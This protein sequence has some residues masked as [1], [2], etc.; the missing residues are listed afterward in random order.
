MKIETHIRNIR[1]ILD[2]EQPDEELIWMG[3]TQSMKNHTKQKRIHYWKY[4]I[5]AAAMIVIAFAAGYHAS[6][7]SEQHL[8]FAHLEPELVKQEAEFVNLINTYTRQIEVEN[9]NL[10]TL[11]I[12]PDDLKYIDK[13]IEAYS[14]DLKQ[15]GANPEL[16]TILL[17]LYE[18][19]I[20][21][22]KNMLNEIKKEKEYENYKHF[23]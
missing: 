8:I 6:R 20:M 9:F 14:A 17:D 23:L 22:L 15:Y 4:A 12:T 10:Q 3:I 19:K 7:K 18:K 11:S 1:P 21:L 2:V 13:L 5:L 16:I